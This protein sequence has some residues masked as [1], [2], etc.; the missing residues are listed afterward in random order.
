MHLTKLIN[1]VGNEVRCWQFALVCVRQV[2]GPACTPQLPVTSV[3]LHRS[4][5][6]W[7]SAGGSNDSMTWNRRAALTRTSTMQFVLS[8]SNL[9]FFLFLH[10][11]ISP[12]FHTLLQSNS[13]NSF[14][15]MQLEVGFINKGLQNKIKSSYLGITCLRPLTL[16]VSSPTVF[17]LC[18]LCDAEAS[19]LKL[20]IS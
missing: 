1:K 12:V 17:T 5:H 4:L 6:H 2:P 18:C 13:M 9:L 7:P 15:H 14:L 16:K 10:V 3:I 20:R 19:F 8:L 11:L